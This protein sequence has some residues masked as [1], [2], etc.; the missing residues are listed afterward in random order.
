M[1]LEDGGVIIAL[2]SAFV[3]LLIVFN[4]I[5]FRLKVVNLHPIF[6]IS[7]CNVVVSVADRDTLVFLGINPT[8]NDWICLTQSISFQFVSIVMFLWV[9]WITVS[10]LLLF[11]DTSAFPEKNWKNNQKFF[12]LVVFG[13]GVVCVFPPNYHN[14]KQ[15]S[16]C[17]GDFFQDDTIFYT[18]F[19]PLAFLWAVNAIGVIFILIERFLSLYKKQN[20]GSG[21]SSVLYMDSNL[22]NSLTRKLVV[23]PLILVLCYAGQLTSWGYS[24]YLPDRNTVLMDYLAHTWTLQGIGNGVAYCVVSRFYLKMLFRKCIKTCGACCV[25]EQQMEVSKAHDCI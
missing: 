1:N 5:V 6:F 9:S 8:A 11:R 3:S 15:G 16:M 25:H 4:F 17:F 23:F 2:V 24:Y 22:A 20:T 13:I 14:M 18:H 21:S 19:I 7:C 10:L 12:H